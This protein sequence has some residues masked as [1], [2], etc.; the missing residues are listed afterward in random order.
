MANCISTPSSE[1]WKGQNITPAL[2]LQSTRVLDG[3]V[4][5]IR[6]HIEEENEVQI[7]LC[8][9]LANMSAP[10]YKQSLYMALQID[11]GIISKFECKHDIF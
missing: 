7:S 6:V 10:H 9:Q 1:S 11:E 4:I 8:Q 3:L 5:Q 2:F